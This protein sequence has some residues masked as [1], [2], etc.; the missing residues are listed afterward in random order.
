M[1]REEAA[2]SSNPDKILIQQSAVL[3]SGLL[4]TANE[5]DTDPITKY[6]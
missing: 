4:S 1:T 2:W 3:G 5:G 6:G